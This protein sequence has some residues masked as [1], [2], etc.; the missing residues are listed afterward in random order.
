MP[1]AA[2]KREFGVA[3]DLASE[4]STLSWQLRAATS[5]AQLRRDQRHVEDARNLLRPIY[6]QF[7]EG[8]V[9][10]DLVEA[11]ICS[12]CWREPMKKCHTT[13]CKL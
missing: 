9:T 3:L 4:Q 2:K 8:F 1:N 5:L 12:T 10:R 6:D 13:I 7:R 11:G